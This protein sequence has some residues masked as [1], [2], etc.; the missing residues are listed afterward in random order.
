MQHGFVLKGWQALAAAGLLLT[1]GCGDT[2][3]Q[4]AAP[5]TWSTFGGALPNSL[6]FALDPVAIDSVM[7]DFLRVEPGAGV[8]AGADNYLQ[9]AQDA[10]LGTFERG[11]PWGGGYRAIEYRK[12]EL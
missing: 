11:D 12:L 4:D 7:A 5:R 1:A 3:G 2:G 8:S 6:F 10:G 9:L